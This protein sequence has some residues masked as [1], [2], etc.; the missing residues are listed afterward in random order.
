M[1]GDISQSLL[2]TATWLDSFF[3][4][5]RATE[6][7]PSYILF[8]YNVFL[9]KGSAPLFQPDLNARLVLPQMQEKTHLVITGTP[10]E[11]NEFSAVQSNSAADQMAGTGDRNLTTALH[12]T[13]VETAV[14]SFVVRG[15]LKFS[16]KGIDFTAGPYYRVT[17]PFQNGWNVRFIE[18]LVWKS[19]EEEG[20]KSS[21]IVDLDRTLPHNLFFRA[22][23]D[24]IHTEHVE[25]FIYALSFS[26]SQPLDSK[27]A[28]AYSWVNVCQTDPVNELT[29]IDLRISYRKR[30]WRSWLF[31]EV[32][33]Q[34]RFPRDRAFEAT[35]GILF[36]LDMFFGKLP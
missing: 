11:T 16:T 5:R 24:W 36:R 25:G 23:T 17:F 10:K 33:P 6:L 30:I 15:G 3:G 1:H 18:D 13:P 19:K 35:P 34:Y 29:E 7:N 20:W 22:S 9:E 27:T 26:V 32:T 2:A 4:D 8:R 21:S 31:Y 14:Q 12:Y 28:L